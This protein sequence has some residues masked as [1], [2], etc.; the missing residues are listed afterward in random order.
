MTY[1]IRRK[2]DDKYFIGFWEKTSKWDISLIEATR[3]K[4]KNTAVL[5]M[6]LEELNKQGY[7][8]NELLIYIVVNPS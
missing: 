8:N 6:V 1:I 5:A 2:K 3:T 4:I 7:S